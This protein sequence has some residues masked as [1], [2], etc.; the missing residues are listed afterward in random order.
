MAYLINALFDDGQLLIS[1]ILDGP[2][3]SLGNHVEFCRGGRQIVG[4]V[5]K[6]RPLRL[7]AL[8][9]PT[10]TIDEV[11]FGEVIQG[12]QN[13]ADSPFLRLRQSIEAAFLNSNAS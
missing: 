10:R 9:G 7:V 12:V 11:H 4:I 13:S 2:T 3:P 8:H 6:I 1:D 5:K